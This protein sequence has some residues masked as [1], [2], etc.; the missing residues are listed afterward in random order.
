MRLT[1]IIATI[2]EFYDEKKIIDIYEAGVNVV[3]INFTHSSPQA[4]AP[5]IK[6][7]NKLNAEKKTA[8]SVLLDTK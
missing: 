6:C 2:T 3:R 1:K 4:A 5:I 7:I 8:L